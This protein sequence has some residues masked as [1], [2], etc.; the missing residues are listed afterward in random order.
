MNISPY[1][2]GLLRRLF[3]LN[4][5]LSA[6]FSAVVPVLLSLSSLHLNAQVQ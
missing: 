5:L 6:Y 2:S 3:C 1:F 4:Y